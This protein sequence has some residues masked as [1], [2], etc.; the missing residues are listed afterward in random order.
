MLCRCDMSVIE[1]VHLSPFVPVLSLYFSCLERVSVHNHV[2]YHVIMSQYVANPF[3]LSV[4][5]RVQEAT[6]F[7]CYT[8]TSAFD[9]LSIHL[10]LRV[11]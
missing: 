5:N 11:L 9:N 4:F 3:S 1:E 2:T 7:S 8:S 10:I 6:R